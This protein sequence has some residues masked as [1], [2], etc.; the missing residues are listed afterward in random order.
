MYDVCIS[1]N[2]LE[3]LGI[4]RLKFSLKPKAPKVV[5]LIPGYGTF[6]MRNTESKE[7]QEN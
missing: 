3:V 2:K 1:M 5:V 4:C 6:S 7:H